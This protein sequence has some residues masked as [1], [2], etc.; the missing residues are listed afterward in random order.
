MATTR[1]RTRRKTAAVEDGTEDGVELTPAA[2][3]NGGNGHD[4]LLTAADL[5]GNFEMPYA[6]TVTIAGVKTYF[7]SRP[8]MDEWE[9]KENSAP[10]SRAR[11]ETDPE[12]LV[13]R[14]D[15]YCLAFPST[16]IKTALMAAGR[17]SPDPSKSGRRT[18]APFIAE[19]FGVAEDSIGFHDAD[20]EEVE[21]WD[22]VDVRIVRYANGRFG[23]RRRPIFHPGWRATFN[24]QILVPELISPGD[25]LILVNRAGMV[26]GIGDNTK[27]GAGRFVVESFSEP[28]IASW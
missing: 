5:F 7:F 20:G 12:S 6:V 26:R 23:P 2:A 4:A 24:L 14:L 18:A 27:F 9:K 8:D 1:P 11:K 21:E 25:V 10:G 22:E 17:Y 19:S 16:Q 13:W 15:N 3:G 28:Y